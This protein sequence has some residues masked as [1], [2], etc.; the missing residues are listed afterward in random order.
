MFARCRTRSKTNVL[1]NFTLQVFVR[2]T[3]GN[4][5]KGTWFKICLQNP[6]TY[7][8]RIVRL[9]SAIFGLVMFRLTK[10]CSI[11]T[12]LVLHPFDWNNDHF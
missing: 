12:N 9:S 7:R 1:T 2:R 10:S 6:V 11:D 8:H 3:Q 4:F 5:V